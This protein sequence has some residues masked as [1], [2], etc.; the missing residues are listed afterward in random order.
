M[1]PAVERFEAM[2]KQYPN[3]DGKQKAFIHF[4]SSVKNEEDYAA[5]EKALANYLASERVKKGFIKN[6]STWF[7][8]W[9]D[10]VDYVEQSP[11]RAAQDEEAKRLEGIKR[12]WG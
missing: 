11:Q 4:K 6:G 7:S 2:W 3:K 1:F 8:G 9:R 12:K 5:I 10:W